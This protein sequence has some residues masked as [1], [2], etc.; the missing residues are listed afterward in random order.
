MFPAHISRKW[1]TAG[2]GTAHLTCKFGTGTAAGG[3]VPTAPRGGWNPGCAHVTFP[4]PG[5]DEAGKGLGQ[6]VG[7]D[8]SPGNTERPRLT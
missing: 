1:C 7:L 2:S 3:A 6:L 5:T 8:P 4:V